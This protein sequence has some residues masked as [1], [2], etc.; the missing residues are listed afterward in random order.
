MSCS[1]GSCLGPF[2]VHKLMCWVAG[3]RRRIFFYSLNHIINHF[4]NPPF[5][6]FFHESNNLTNCLITLPCK[7]V[8]SASARYKSVLPRLISTGGQLIYILLFRAQPTNTPLLCC[9]VE[10]ILYCVSSSHLD[11]NVHHQHGK[12]T[13]EDYTNLFSQF[14]GG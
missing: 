2:K 5:I 6:L 8:I 9:F 10:T 3:G 14:S 4:F 12:Q 13:V 7:I 11:L 1:A